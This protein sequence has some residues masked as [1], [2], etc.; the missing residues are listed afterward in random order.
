MR[1]VDDRGELHLQNAVELLDH[2]LDVKLESPCHRVLLPVAIFLIRSLRRY[3]FQPIGNESEQFVGG[4]RSP[5]PPRAARQRLKSGGI[6]T[7]GKG[8]AGRFLAQAQ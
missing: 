2:D 4:L 1:V 6:G 3:R 8:V 5:R 7:P